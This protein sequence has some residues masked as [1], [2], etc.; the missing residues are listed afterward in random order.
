MSVR[1]YTAGDEVR[2]LVNGRELAR[3]VVTPADKLTASFEV[4]YEPGELTAVA[5]LSGREVARKRLETV[6]LPARV[7][8]R[9]ERRQIAASPNDLAY[10]FAEICDAQGRK[11]PD[12]ANALE[13][14]VEG[15]ARLRATGSANPRGIKSFSAPTCETF[16]GV[17]L[18]IIQPTS[19]QGRVSVQV[20]GHGLRGDAISLQ[21]I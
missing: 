8:L 14:A 10:V 6:G 12:A 11:V 16:H 20:R 2:L 7:R 18:A 13:F 4:P 21:I 3:K 5:F 1:A 19:R 9:A 15:P 17:A